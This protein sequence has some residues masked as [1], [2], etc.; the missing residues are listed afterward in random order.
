MGIPYAKQDISQEDEEAVLHALRSDYL[1]QGP[2]VPQFEHDLALYAGATSAVVVNSATSALHIACLSLGL[3]PGDRLWTSP[4]SFVASANCGIYCGAEIDFVDIDPSTYN[5][6]PLALEEKLRVS[7][8]SGLLPKIIVVVHFSGQSCEMGAISEIAKRYG[9]A[10]IEDAS[11]AMG[12]HYLSAPIGGCSY[13]DIT[14]FSFHPVKIITS[15]EGGAALTNSEAL[16][17]KMCLL[18][19][20]GVTR[21]HNH[22]TEDPH[23]PWYYQQLALGFNYRMSDLHAALGISQL[24]RVLSF[25]EKRNTLAQRYDER[26]Q[27][28][29]LQLP[30]QHADTYSS[31]HLYVIRLALDEISLSHHEVFVA[32]RDSGIGVNLHYIPIHLQPFYQQRGFKAGDFPHAEAYYREAISLPLFSAMTV[33]QQDTVVDT[34]TSILQG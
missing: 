15:A 23:G 28:L 11:H 32:L 33:T 25:V 19:S 8:T 1:T 9:V 4:I 18:R 27:G 6:C 29:A 10:I 3:G 26:L 13:S 34:L 5:L 16:A 21:D 31:R 7:E 14:V 2:L 22:M 12:G 17:E 20:H 30:F 24:K